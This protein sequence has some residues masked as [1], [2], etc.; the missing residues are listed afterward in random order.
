VHRQRARRCRPHTA[1]AERWVAA[2]WSAVA[3]AIGPA[4]LH[5]AWPLAR[6]GF[7]LLFRPAEHMGWELGFGL[8][9][10]FIYFS[11]FR[12]YLNEIQIVLFVPKLIGS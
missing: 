7:D 1:R 9:G 8:Q 6:G 11:Y 2:F 12:I 4:Q 10:R 3:L 5:A